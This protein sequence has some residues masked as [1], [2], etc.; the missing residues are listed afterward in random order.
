MIH[1]LRDPLGIGSKFLQASRRLSTPSEVRRIQSAVLITE[2][3]VPMVVVVDRDSP[4]IGQERPG[5]MSETGMRHGRGL[6]FGVHRPRTR[7]R[8]SSRLATV[9]GVV[10]RPLTDDMNTT[11][12]DVTDLREHR[13]RH[14]DLRDDVDIELLCQIMKG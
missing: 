8:T 2:L 12:P 14:R 9:P 6:D 10:N 13:L 1:S 3:F 11:R 4:H 5:S 7:L